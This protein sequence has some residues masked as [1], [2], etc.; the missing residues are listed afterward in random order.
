MVPLPF[1]LSARA[2]GSSVTFIFH[3]F[4]KYHL[5]NADNWHKVSFI[6]PRTVQ[7]CSICGLKF[8][9]GSEN[10]GRECGYVSLIEWYHFSQGSGKSFYII[11]SRIW[12]ISNQGLQSRFPRFCLMIVN[13]QIYF[14]HIFWNKQSNSKTRCWGGDLLIKMRGNR[15]KKTKSGGFYTRLKSVT[16]GTLWRA[17]SL[18]QTFAGRNFARNFRMFAKVLTCKI[19]LLR[20]LASYWLI[21]YRKMVKIP[22]SRFLL[23]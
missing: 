7:Q 18:V 10:G 15:R 1:P 14:Q 6:N 13:P 16:F 2:R 9:W 8:V 20:S 21:K 22:A 17:I 3:L 12:S 4:L 23:K 19:V 11:F 5:S